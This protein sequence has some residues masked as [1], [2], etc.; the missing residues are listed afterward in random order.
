[1]NQV[2]M[3]SEQF[4]EYLRTLGRLE[5]TIFE[6]QRKLFAKP[7]LRRVIL[8]SKSVAANTTDTLKYALEFEAKIISIIGYAESTTIQL[9][10][11]DPKSSIFENPSSGED[12]FPMP[13]VPLELPNMYDT[14][15]RNKELAVEF[16]NTHGSN[17]YG[18]ILFILVEEAS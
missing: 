2:L 6:L 18:A 15:E 4:N 13:T 12:Y 16:K 3:S 14:W 5:H 9:R 17:A 8:F 7:K 11:L 10:I 1:M